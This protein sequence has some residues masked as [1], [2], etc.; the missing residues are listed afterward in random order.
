MSEIV[1]PSTET[2]TPHI[3][4]D[5]ADDQDDIDI[6]DHVLLPEVPHKGL[7][8]VGGIY[9]G[10]WSSYDSLTIHYPLTGSSHPGLV[11]GRAAALPP[12]RPGNGLGTTL[13]DLV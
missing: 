3:K 6:V 8:F 2:D 1:E 13:L 5:G 4:V 7:V 11:G 9:C 10:S 12:L